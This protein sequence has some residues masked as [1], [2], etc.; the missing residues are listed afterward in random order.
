MGGVAYFGESFPTTFYTLMDPH[1]YIEYKGERYSE[2][3]F[4][5]AVSGSPGDSG[6]N[7]VDL[8]TGELLWQVI[9]GDKRT[10]PT[11][12]WNGTHFTEGYIGLDGT[13][14]KGADGKIYII[15]KPGRQ[16]SSWKT[17]SNV[18]RGMI[19][20]SIDFLWR[21][22]YV[23]CFG[24]GPTQFTQFDTDKAEVTKGNP[25]TISGEVEDL[26]P[27]NP[28]VP[29]VNL[30]IKI[31]Y[32]DN[33]DDVHDIITVHTDQNGKFSYKWVP[34]V[35]GTLTLRAESAG[36]PAYEAP[37]NRFSAIHVSEA[38]QMEPILTGALIGAII[39]AIGVPV[40]ISR[41][42]KAGP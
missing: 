40:I 27:Y 3:P 39:V 19:H 32:L 34:W 21:P 38:S 4:D 6:F 1:E 26:S 41:K 33:N 35:T 24:P 29:A 5:H 30:P 8:H 17:S 15:E 20:P 42:R 37:D 10:A 31:T 13:H 2:N 9:Y 11:G 7:A 36:S 25:L 14:P 28:G 16:T 23:Y 12:G 18:D 22:G